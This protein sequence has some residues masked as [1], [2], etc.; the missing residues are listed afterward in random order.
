M[1]TV[2]LGSTTRALVRAE[3]VRLTYA[4]QGDGEPLVLMMGL[5]AD[6][7]AWERRMAAWDAGFACYAVDNRGAGDS[8]Q[9]AGQYRTAE[10][11]DDY[12]GLI[13]SL[14]LG[15]VPVIGISM[16]GA[17][18]QELALNHPD[19][20]SRLVLVSSWARRSKSGSMS[21]EQTSTI[22]FSCQTY[23]WQMSGTTYTGQLPRFVEVA[24]GAG[25]AGLEAEPFMLGDY[26]D[27]ARAHAV[28]DP[29]DLELSSVAFVAGP[30]SARET[31][32]ERGAADHFIRFVSSF[33]GAL[34]LLVQAPGPDR[35][36]LRERQQNAIACVSAITERAAAAGVRTSFHANSPAGSVFRTRE[37]YEILLD[38]LLRRNRLHTGRRAPGQRRHGPAG[39]H[40]HVSQPRG[41]HPPQ[42]LLAGRRL[43]THRRGSV[44]FPGIVTYL[45][46]T[47]YGG[48]IVVED[49]SDEAITDPD[50]VTRAAGAYVRSVLEP[51]T[52][53][54]DHINREA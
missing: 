34:L 23:A 49:E 3:G 15:P 6:R 41:P 18:A 37:D 50:A 5:G 51:V 24:S 7:T 53:R 45:R 33:P 43:A 25:F 36:D 22:R 47:G 52:V 48:W 4:R 13:T 46:D 28:I 20:V 11:A 16:G 27:I 54:A 2:T 30:R 14:G 42:G 31:D 8:D 44:D 19:L 17:I 12:A 32:E 29:S 10:M 21:T 26:S 38:G 9:P 1:T 39:C 40:P 35:E